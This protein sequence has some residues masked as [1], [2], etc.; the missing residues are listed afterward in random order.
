MYQKIDEEGQIECSQTAAEPVR[1]QRNYVAI[2][3]SL[4]LLSLLIGGSYLMQGQQATGA[5]S[6]ATCF[7]CN[8]ATCSGPKK[9]STKPRRFLQA[10]CVSTGPKSSKCSCSCK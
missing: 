6:L 7:N 4:C 3:L 5:T 1:K 2:L 10:S 8:T 9:C